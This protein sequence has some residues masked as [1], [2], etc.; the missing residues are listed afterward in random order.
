MHIQP[1]D[2][3][4]LTRLIQNTADGPLALVLEGGYGPS[5]GEAVRYIISALTREDVISGLDNPPALP[6]TRAL[7]SLLKKYHGLS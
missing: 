2:F 4:V 1:K 3:E 5:H 6:A 7:V